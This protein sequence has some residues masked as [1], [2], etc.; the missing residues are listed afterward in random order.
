MGKMDDMLKNLGPLAS[1]LGS[2]MGKNAR[3]NK[4]AF[5]NLMKK[6]EAKE[7]MLKTIQKRKEERE[8]QAKLEEER[9]A[10][11]LQQSSVTQEQI[12]ALLNE[13][14][15]NEPLSKKQKPVQSK[16][17]KKKKNKK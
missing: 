1:Q 6:E 9:K 13:E 14:W 11:R 2:S 5:N 17:K 3:F 12:E 7:R 15:I 4:G 16:N 8:K 10:Q